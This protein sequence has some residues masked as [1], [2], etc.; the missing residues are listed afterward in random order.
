VYEKL[1]DGIWVYNGVFE[2]IDA[3]LETDGIRQVFKF[4]LQSQP[5][6]AS[7]QLQTD[8]DHNRFIPSSVKIEV[9]KRDKGRCVICGDNK[10]LHYDHIIPFS[11]GGTSL[12]SENIQLLCAKHNLQKKDKII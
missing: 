12:K 8:L 2:L 10:N 7:P 6:D 5:L 11:K 1:R 4:K 9:W 3:W